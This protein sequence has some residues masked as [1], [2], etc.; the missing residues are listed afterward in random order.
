MWVFFIKKG[1]V[2]LSIICFKILIALLVNLF[3]YFFPP[4]M[5]EALGMVQFTF[6]NSWLFGI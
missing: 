5:L 3:I 2:I 6:S 4:N 1:H